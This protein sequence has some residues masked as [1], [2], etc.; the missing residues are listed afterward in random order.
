MYI[1]PRDIFI[2]IIS[3]LRVQTFII[4][5]FRGTSIELIKDETKSNSY[6]VHNGTKLIKHVVLLVSFYSHGSNNVLSAG[7]YES[8]ETKF[9]SA[10]W[11]E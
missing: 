8:F 6:R 5:Y 11:D 1:A 4:N 9:S 10:S 3:L 7:F 2:K